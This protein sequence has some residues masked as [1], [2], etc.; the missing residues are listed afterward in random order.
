MNG[1]PS[2]C[3]QYVLIRPPPINQEVLIR[4]DPSIGEQLLDYSRGFHRTESRRTN[5]FFILCFS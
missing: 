5:L 3:R 2:S 1:T 4:P